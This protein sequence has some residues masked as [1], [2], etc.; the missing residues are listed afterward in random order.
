MR[1]SKVFGWVKFFLRG[2]KVEKIENIQYGRKKLEHIT[3]TLY[4]IVIAFDTIILHGNFD[5]FNFN[6]L[7]FFGAKFSAVTNKL[8][9][10]ERKFWT[11][12][13]NISK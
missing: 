11:I 4:I 6:I 9:S 3:K 8:I 7:M 2:S 13:E 5:F 10:I 1:W 12:K